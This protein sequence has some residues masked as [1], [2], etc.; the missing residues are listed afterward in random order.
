MW[1]GGGEK[2]EQEREWQ[3]I[4]STFD[5]VCTVSDEEGER[6]RMLRGVRQS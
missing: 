4:K 1:R 2:L 6:G 3:Y 5:T